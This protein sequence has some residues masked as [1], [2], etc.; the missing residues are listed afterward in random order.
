M[1]APGQEPLPEG[2]QVV[3]YGIRGMHLAYDLLEAHDAL[4]L[5]DA[6]P[7]EREPGEIVLLEVGPEDL[8]A[9]GFDA[10]GMEPVSVLASLSVLGG[11][12]PP[13]YVVGC[14][15]ATIEEGMGL[16]EPVAAAVPRAVTALRELLA[17]RLCQPRTA[18]PSAIQARKS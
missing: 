13:T 12:L 5:V 18:Q 8:G 14:S 6:I 15:P 17:E 1:L 2:V 10:H 4:V 9:G 16:S 3:D 7:G 11:T